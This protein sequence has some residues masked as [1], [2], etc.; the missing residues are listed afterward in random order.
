MNCVKNERY[1]NQVN[2]LYKNMLMLAFFTLFS[3]LAKGQN[4]KVLNGTI[5]QNG[6]IVKVSNAVLSNKHSG[7]TKSD[8]SGRFEISVTVTD[9]VRI[10]CEGYLTKYIYIEKQTETKDV[11]VYLNLTDTLKE[12]QIKGRLS[13]PGMEE[14]ASKFTLEKGIFYKGKPPI[15][16]L[17]PFNGK[18]L[19]FFH[20]LLGKD[21]KRARRLYKLSA[22][23]AVDNE[24]DEKFNDRTI[25]TIIPIEDDQIDQFITD[26]RPTVKE[27]RKW[28]AYELYNYIKKSYEDFKKKNN[29]H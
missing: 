17:S 26:Y 4:K 1:F 8:Q 22:Q 20:E 14:I 10:T 3:A 19:T 7:M 15:A 11:I 9:T 28:S 18:P 27:I 5:F 2:D 24:V 16:L 23:Q 6:T 13:R 29:N 25:R 12:V 21:G